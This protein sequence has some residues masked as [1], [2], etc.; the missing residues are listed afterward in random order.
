M[1][2][3]IA[4]IVLPA[5]RSN[6]KLIRSRA[7][8]AGSSGPEVAIIPVV[9]ADA[10]GHG[11]VAVSRELENQG[12][13]WLA[14]AC[15]EEAMELRDAGISAEIAILGP[16]KE[17]EFKEAGARKL[18]PVLSSPDD[19]S[20]LGSALG[21]RSGLPL[22]VI[23]DVDTGMG[24]MGF[25]PEEMADA[26]RRLRELK[27]VRA[28]GLFS[29]LSVA[30]CAGEDDREYTVRQIEDFK[31]IAAALA[32]TL[33]ELSLFALA[34]SGGLF[35]HPAATM[36]AARPGITLYGVRP[37]P[38]LAD[39]SG[40][41]PVMRL[42]TEIAQVRS[43]PAGASVS[44]GRK[45]V[46]A[47]PSKIALLPVGYADGL[48]RS[49]P[50]GFAFLVRGQRAPIVGVVTMD[51]TMVDVTEI[52][53]AKVGDR[54]LVMGRERKDAGLKSGLPIEVLVEEH[55]RAAGAIVYEI[56]TGI[57]KRVPRV[58]REEE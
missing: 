26:G 53:E 25:L 50:P 38:E 29:H 40:L 3:T 52:P 5:L 31:L 45:T 8:A 1:R 24:R 14:V 2:P 30:D 16:L 41:W 9:K 37:N 15:L 20:R 39:P 49:L 35:F 28:V 47:R 44:Y 42:V 18:T 46:L 7:A 23:L 51:F 17:D 4:E 22:S 43:L 48:K 57:G 55:A 10:Y 13:K 34:N 21:K 11:A 58:Y 19:L 6:L 27:A 54:V 56:L 12:I 36:N 33:P 32:K